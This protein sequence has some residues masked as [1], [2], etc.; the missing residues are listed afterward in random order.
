LAQEGKELMKI[1]VVDDEQPI[2]ELLDEFLSIQGFDVT[3]AD[4]GKAALSKFRDL[5]PHAVILDIKM[6]GINGIEVLHKIKEINGD[7]NIIVLSAF[8]D[9]GTR[10]TALKGGADYYMEKPMDLECLLRVLKEWR[11]SRSVP[12]LG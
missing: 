9:A 8:G 4:N 12:A 6:P 2:C 11:D 5:T 1:L 7:T 10:E 3:T